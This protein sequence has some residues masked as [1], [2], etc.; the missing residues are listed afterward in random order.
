MLIFAC[1]VSES[2]KVFNA[3]VGYFLQKC[4]L[5]IIRTERFTRFFHQ[6]L[7]YMLHCWYVFA[8]AWQLNA[9]S[10]GRSGVVTVH[11]KLTLSTGFH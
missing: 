10:V 11:R 3:G 9:I 4:Y 7:T 5:P 1:M 8:T 6:V 2:V